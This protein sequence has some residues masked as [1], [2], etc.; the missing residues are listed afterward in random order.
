MTRGVILVRDPILMVGA[1]IVGVPSQLS[2]MR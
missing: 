1:S 2:E